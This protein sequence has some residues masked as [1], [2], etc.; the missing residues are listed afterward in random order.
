MNICLPNLRV[1]IICL[2][3]FI[4]EV[5]AQDENTEGGRETQ[6][7]FK[8]KGK[9]IISRMYNPHPISVGEIINFSIDP[10]K[11]HFFNIEDE[12]AIL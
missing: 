3:F 2:A 5:S 11:A 10:K 9:E 6:L 1:I 8:L 4:G 12:K 7:F